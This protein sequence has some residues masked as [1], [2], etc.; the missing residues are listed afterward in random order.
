M[1]MWPDPAFEGTTVVTEVAVAALA[2]VLVML[3]AG[4]SFPGVVL[5]LVPVMVSAVPATPLDG[6]KLVIVGT[7]AAAVTVNEVRLVTDPEGAVTVIGPVV[8]PEG[9]LATSWFTD[10]DVIVADFP[11]NETLS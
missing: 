5:N 8:A 2:S 6:L 9:T 3:S 1:E 11:L 7:A 4:L 10:A